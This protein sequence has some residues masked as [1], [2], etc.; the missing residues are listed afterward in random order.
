[1]KC[2]GRLSFTSIMIAGVFVAGMWPT[3]AT[4]DNGRKLRA[5]V[6]EYF[7]KSHQAIFLPQNPTAKSGNVLTLPGGTT[8]IE[9]NVCYDLPKVKYYDIELAVMESDSGI[10]ALLGAMLPAGRLAE[11]A[12]SIGGDL[13]KS[14]YLVVNPLNVDTPP[15]GTH[16]FEKPKSVADCDIIRNMF[17]GISDGRHIL[18]TTILHGQF[19]AGAQFRLAGQAGAN[20]QIAPEVVDAINKLI[21]ID[22][23]P[24]AEG[25]VA[26][27]GG[28]ATVNYTATPSP[29]S[30]AAQSEFLDRG[31]LERLYRQYNG[32]SGVQI[33]QLV[34]EYI[35]QPSSDAAESIREQLK[36][37][38]TS[39]EIWFGSVGD[40]FSSVF[41]GKEVTPMGPLGTA[42]TPQEQW[43]ALAVIA[44]AHEI[45]GDE[46]E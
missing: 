27:D 41:A 5:L 36:S 23:G 17:N 31:E 21:K 33:K 7:L 10:S 11:I 9:R 12:A 39:S 42:E 45:A 26:V 2:N 25:H 34:R 28:F 29:R 38:L 35:L 3:W 22:L 30:L 20:A 1:M 40:L 6:T 24:I 15:S 14:T 46:K 43:D 8:Y 19:T 37:L 13:T 18:A 4:A 32:G 16:V 44:A